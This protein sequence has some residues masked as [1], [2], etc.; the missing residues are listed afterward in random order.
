VAYLQA[1]SS[2]P[3]RPG[4]VILTTRNDYVSN[5]IQLLA[6]QKRFGIRL[7]RAPDRPEGGVD[8]SAMA[9]LI[10][11]HHPALVCV[12]QVPTNSGLVQEVEAIGAACREADCLYLVDA[13]QSAGQMPL[14]VERIGCDF[15]SVTF[16]KYLR[17][18]RGTGFLYVSDRALDRGLEPLFID[19]RGAEWI[20]SDS[21]RPVDDARR[22]E[23]W[24]S[25]WAMVLGAGEAARYAL[26]VGLEAIQ[27]RVRLLAGHL[28]QRLSMLN[29]VQ[30]LDRGTEL[31]G[32]VSLTIRGWEPEVLARRLRERGI[33]VHP[34]R[35]AFAIIDC[36]DKKVSGSLRISPHYF[37][38][39]EEI[40]RTVDEVSTV[41]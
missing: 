27:Q 10:R 34:Q 8:P 26:A 38:T 41:V 35:R 3:F 33:I 40:H 16:R 32:I 22:F 30:I 21:Y 19:L 2:V 11:R 14:D 25:A 17:G 9:D 28:R 1:L 6:L 5:Q 37:N 39:D 13:C 4:E 18:P 36:D 15:M 20:T 24:E 31:C 12:T 7:I 29:A 23:T